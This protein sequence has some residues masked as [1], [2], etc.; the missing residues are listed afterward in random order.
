M[1]LLRG[2]GVDAA[3]A[4]VSTDYRQAVAELVPA[5]EDFDHAIVQVR[6][7]EALHW[8]DVT[9]TQQ[10]GPLTQDLRDQFRQ[11]VRLAAWHHRTHRL[12]AA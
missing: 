1:T 5:P 2:V 11:G 12:S 4:L 3:P 7:G 9:R 8:L 10:R 6:L